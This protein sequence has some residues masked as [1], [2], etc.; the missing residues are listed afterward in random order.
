L[1]KRPNTTPGSRIHAPPP[2]VRP[3]LG[4]HRGFTPT[5]FREGQLSWSFLPLS[6]REKHVPTHHSNRSGLRWALAHLLCPLLTPAPRSGFLAVPS[7]P[8]WDTVQTSRGKPDRLHCTPAGFT[9]IALGGCGLRYPLLTR[10]VMTA[11]Y[12]VS[13]RQVAVLLHASFRHHLAVMPLRF[14]STS[15]PPGCAG[16]SHPQAV[17]HARHTK[18]RA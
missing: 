16:D 8:L 7:V 2:M 1:V 14:A 3:F 17:K 6:T 5:L 11:S 18:K 13:V 9:A 12:P 15:P 10:P 4:S